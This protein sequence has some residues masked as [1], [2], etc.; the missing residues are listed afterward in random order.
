M[1]D[2]FCQGASSQLLAG[3]RNCE[4]SQTSLDSVKNF[5]DLELS[6]VKEGADSAAL[7]FFNSSSQDLASFEQDVLVQRLVDG[8]D[9]LAVF[10][11]AQLDLHIITK[12]K[13]FYIGGIISTLCNH[14]RTSIIAEKFNLAPRTVEIEVNDKLFKILAGLN[15]TKLAAAMADDFEGKDVGPASASPVRREFFRKWKFRILKFYEICCVEKRL[16]FT[17]LPF[18]FLTRVFPDL[19]ST[20]RIFR[21]I[22]THPEDFPEW[23]H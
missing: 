16:I 17:D 22:K 19:E 15:A 18:S 10:C 1:T 6:G 5:V 13:L 23:L 9:G 11:Q 12:L 20:N 8:L 7:K 4:F 2:L 21:Y 3:I 14:F